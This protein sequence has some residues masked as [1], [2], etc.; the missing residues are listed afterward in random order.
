MSFCLAST[1]RQALLSSTPVRTTRFFNCQL[2]WRRTHFTGLSSC[3]PS[4]SK[5]V[6]AVHDAVHLLPNTPI[7]IVDVSPRTLRSYAR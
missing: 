5:L 1:L 7:F 4:L 2:L 6:K 3:L